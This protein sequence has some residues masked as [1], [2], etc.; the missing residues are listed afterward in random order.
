MIYCYALPQNLGPKIPPIFSDNTQFGKPPLYTAGGQPSMRG[1]DG[2]RATEKKAKSSKRKKYVPPAIS[3]PGNVIRVPVGGGKMGNKLAHSGEAPMAMGVAER[4]VRWFCRPGGVV[5][6]PCCG[7]GTT[8][9]AAVAAGRR[10]FGCD[11]RKSRA[12]QGTMKGRTLRTDRPVVP[13]GVPSSAIPWPSR[14]RP[15][16]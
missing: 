2:M 9:H 13:V 10:G 11:M 15:C 14:L 4:F 5:I 3:N 8:I 1:R 12:R 16:R 6:D 7:T